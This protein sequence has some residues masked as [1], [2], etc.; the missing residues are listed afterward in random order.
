MPDS[1]L[2]TGATG[3]L[4]Q[5]LHR[6]L[7]PD[8]LTLGR[9]SNNQ[10]I[11]DLS[12]TIPDLP[13][14]DTVI[15]NAGKA[16]VV[17][18]TP[19]EEQA[20]FDVN[21]QGTANLL[22]GLESHPPKQL[23]FISSVAVYGLDMGEAIPE[24]AP[25]HGQTPY[26]RSKIQA[27]ALVQDFCKA[28]D[29]G[30]LILRLPLVVGPN[31]PG[32]LGAMVQMIRKGRY[33]RIG[34]NKARKSMVLGTDVAHLV[35]R[36][37]G[38]PSGIYNLTDGIHPSFADLEEAIASVYGQKLRWSAPMPLLRL[39]ALGGDVLGQLGI[40]FPLNTDRLQKM[41]ATLTFSD[42]KARHEL[43]W[44]PR[45]VLTYLDKIL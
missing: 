41:T 19:E 8:I 29:I 20:F 24:T 18:Q 34:G 9:A 7:G 21:V 16:H 13:P 42:A 12:T 30:Y 39:A 5:M 37:S 44:H 2:L 22:Q 35:A 3:F 45:P 15:H 23:V 4:G 43:G 14:V 1:T 26:A 17:P 33:I 38:Q 28:H 36:L 10:L 6:A 31:P 11:V 32:N 25:L 27:E 40:S